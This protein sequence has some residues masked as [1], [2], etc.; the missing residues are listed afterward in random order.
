MT[1]R[2][3]EKILTLIAYHD[4]ELPD[5]ELSMR[6]LLNKSG[7]PLFPDLGRLQVADM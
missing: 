6:K 7:I 4:C 5:T 1:T 2:R 3:G